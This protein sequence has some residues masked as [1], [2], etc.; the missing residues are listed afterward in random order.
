[1]YKV[2]FDNSGQTC[3]KFWGY[4][5]PLTDAILHGQKYIL[6][7]YDVSIDSYPNLLNNGYFYYPFYS[8]KLNKKYGIK[9]YMNKLR[10]LMRSRYFDYTNLPKRWPHVF[11]DGWS[12]RY[13]LLDKRAKDEIKRV[14]MPKADIA[15]PTKELFELQRRKNN[16]IV[17]VHIRRGDYEK[18]HEGRYFFSFEEYASLCKQIVYKYTD[19]KIVFFL[20]SN[21]D[22]PFLTFSELDYFVNPLKSAV[23][24]LYSLS[25]CDLI[26]GPPS[27]FSRFASYYGEVPISFIT[28]INNHVFN[29]RS[30]ENYNTYSNGDLVEFDF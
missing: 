6:P 11:I 20:S 30:I 10:I 13:N 24:D 23:A 21:E 1:M 14:F 12:T 29:F 28:N 5:Y 17:G 2:L 7:F 9:E 27:S 4:L 8:I 15:L 19:R 3:N 18:W 22:I 25:L 16:C 26:I